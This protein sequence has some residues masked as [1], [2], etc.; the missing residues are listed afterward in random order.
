M[1]LS[2]EIQCKDL[3]SRLCFVALYGITASFLSIFSE[4]FHH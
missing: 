4:L 3:K 2:S 1:E